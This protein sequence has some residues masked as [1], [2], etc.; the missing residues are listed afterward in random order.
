MGTARTINAARKVIVPVDD[1][2][3]AIGL[4]QEDFTKDVWKAGQYQGARYG[5][6]LDFHSVGMYWNTKQFAKAKIDATPKDQASLTE[7][8]DI[9]RVCLPGP[10]QRQRR[11]LLSP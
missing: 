7:A 9:R 2:A 10:H 4:T 6:P 8:L 3:T 1:V 11:N 5:I